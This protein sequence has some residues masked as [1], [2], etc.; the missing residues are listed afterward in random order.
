MIITGKFPGDNYIF[1]TLARSLASSLH[2]FFVRIDDWR[3]FRAILGDLIG[4]QHAAARTQQQR[5]RASASE[6]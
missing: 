1:H 6:D 2:Q 4:T 3:D 5:A